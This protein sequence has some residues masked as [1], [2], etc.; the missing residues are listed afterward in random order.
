MAI[1]RRLTG[2]TRPARKNPAPPPRALTGFDH[3]ADRAFK[4][5]PFYQAMRILEQYP[6]P[7][8]PR[9]RAPRRSAREEE[10]EAEN[11]Q[12]RAF[13]AQQQAAKEADAETRK[14]TRSK[15][16]DGR[17]PDAPVA[18]GRSRGADRPVIL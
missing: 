13:I 6:L 10:L 15:P 1:L 5:T 4:L 3:F 17:D 8:L 12:M 9:Q 14:S 2:S 18:G 11:R 7:F 16:E